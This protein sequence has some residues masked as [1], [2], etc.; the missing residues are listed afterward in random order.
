MGG[1]EADDRRVRH[2]TGTQWERLWTPSKLK[3][4]GSDERVLL[5]LWWGRVS[6]KVSF[7]GGVVESECLKCLHD[8]AGEWAES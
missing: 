6:E 5:F 3:V 2:W 7:S 1:G 4:Y 8:G